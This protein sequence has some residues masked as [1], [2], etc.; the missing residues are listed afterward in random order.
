[1]IKARNLVLTIVAALLTIVVPTSCIEDGMATSPSE[2]P[3]FSVDTLVIDNMFTDETTTTRHFVV[4]NRNSKILNISR[5][6]FVNDGQ[7]TFRIN[8]DG[9][10]GTKFENIEIRPNDSI[11]VFVDANVAPTAD[12]NAVAVDEQ[13]AFLTNGVEHRMVVS[14]RGRNVERLAGVVISRDTVWDGGHSRQIFDS[15]VVARGATLTIGAGA[16][17]FFHDKAFMK[18][19]GTLVADGTPE[20]PIDFRG[21]RRGNVAGDIPFDLMASQ[22]QGIYFS[23]SSSGNRMVHT[24]VRNTVG[25]VEIDSTAVA[26]PWPALDLL[27]CRFRNSASYALSARHAGV[28]A[29]GCE[30]A[31]AA[32]GVVRLEGGEHQLAYCTIA[33]YY[34]FTAIRGAA[35]QLR[36]CGAKDEEVDPAVS[37]P[38]MKADVSNTIIYGIGADLNYGDFAGSEV[39]FKR[40]LFK[41]EGSDDDNMQQCLWGV[42]PLYATDRPAYIFDYRLMENSPALG[43]ADAGLLPAAPAVTFDGTARPVPASLGAYEAYPK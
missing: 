6:A 16:E 24:V 39:V 12:W 9:Q 3:V 26:A 25:G 5:I 13:L 8:V 19:D 30:F 10:S 27:N 21:D 7:S 41:S 31:D 29:V 43:A 18:V 42:D 20:R 22:W 28:R 2:Q 4:Y 35:L 17:L 14:A 1:M 32:D 40:C 38:L 11:F 34:L 33:N 37:A 15:L 36:H 23:P